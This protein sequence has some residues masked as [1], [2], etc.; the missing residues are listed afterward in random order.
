MPI[1]EFACQLAPLDPPSPEMVQLF[2]AL[3]ENQADTDR[4]FGLFAQTASLAKFFAPENLARITG[5]PPGT[6]AT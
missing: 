5:A 1:Y 6:A 4:L 2:G 3:P